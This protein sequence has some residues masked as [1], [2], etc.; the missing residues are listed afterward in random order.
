MSAAGI[1]R[2]DPSLAHALDGFEVPPAD[3]DFVERMVD[4]AIRRRAISPVVPALLRRIRGGGRPWARRGIIGAVA[5]GLATATAA[6]TGSFGLF[7]DPIRSVAGLLA[8]PEAPAPI[9]KAAARH[10]AAPAL[11]AAPAPAEPLVAASDAP[12]VTEQARAERR[13]QLR[14]IAPEERKAIFIATVSRVQYQLAMRGIDVPRAVIR[15]RLLARLADPDRPLPPVFARAAARAAVADGSRA[16]SAPPT[17]VKAED[18]ADMPDAPTGE[19]FSPPGASPV[20]VP[21]ADPAEM[22]A[23]ARWEARRRMVRAWRLAQIARAREAEQAAA[24]TTP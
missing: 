23:L 4:G 18:A 3:A 19:A 17:T 5:V 1:A 16:R 20:A 13:A 11:A 8:P 2:I 15:R 7:P 24:T 10:H 22:A 9:K 14:A 12:V 21:P 6:A